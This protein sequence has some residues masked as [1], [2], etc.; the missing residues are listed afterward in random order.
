MFFFKPT[1]LGSLGGKWY[2]KYTSPIEH[3]AFSDKLAHMAKWNGKTPPIFVL[4]RDIEYTS[5]FMVGKIPWRIHGTLVYFY[6]LTPSKTTIHV[7]IDIPVLWIRIM[8]C[9]Q[10]T[11][12][13]KGTA[14]LL[15]K[16]GQNPERIVS[17]TWIFSL[18]S[19]RGC[20]TFFRTLRIWRTLLPGRGKE[21]VWLAGVCF[22][23][24]KMTPV[25]WGSLGILREARNQ[26]ANLSFGI[27]PWECPLQ[28]VAKKIQGNVPPPPQKKNLG[29]GNSNIFGIFTP[30]L[31]K[32]N[33]CWLVH[34]FQRRCFNHQLEMASE[35]IEEEW[36]FVICPDE[37]GTSWCC[38]S[39]C[40]FLG[41]SS[42]IC[43]FLVLEI[44]WQ[45][46]CRRVL[47]VCW[48]QNWFGDGKS[49]Y[50]SFGVCMY[51]CFFLLM[52]V[53]SLNCW[54][55]NTIEISLW[56]VFFSIGKATTKN[57]NQ[58]SKHP[59]T[60]TQLPAPAEAIVAHRFSLHVSNLGGGGMKR[61]RIPLTVEGPDSNKVTRLTPEASL[62]M[63]LNMGPL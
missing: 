21:P 40:F 33:P 44:L 11:R 53:S 51:V 49:A 38:W 23:V 29:G 50:M 45:F 25:T 30:Y 62:E 57:S 61:S 55:S 60:T 7:R 32:T 14:S 56:C 27:Q 39:V 22:G 63:E 58:Q 16:I 2:G 1:K 35:K 54:D 47:F 41:T 15:L 10:L 4:L 5:S 48:K 28:R 43:R 19:G 36:I 52:N 8:G 12:T 42:A 3:L 26:Q 9:K 13:M 31:G 46:L 34:M 18:V 59:S 20:K 37:G 24:L 17:Q 6:L